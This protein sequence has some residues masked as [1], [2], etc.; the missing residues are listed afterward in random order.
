M[1]ICSTSE[2]WQDVQRKLL[3]GEVPEL[4][5]YPDACKLG[6]EG[7]AQTDVGVDI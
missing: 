1:R 5:M 2:Y 6:V 4:Q 3:R 7:V